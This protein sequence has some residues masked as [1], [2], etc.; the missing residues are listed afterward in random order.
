MK[1]TPKINEFSVFN[2]DEHMADLTNRVL[3]PGLS[4]RTMQFF[5]DRSQRAKTIAKAKADAAAATV[6][7]VASPSGKVTLTQV[8]ADD[9][10]DAKDKSY[11]NKHV[12][13][14]KEPKVLKRRRSK[15]MEEKAEL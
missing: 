15:K 14:A 13:A 8:E 11:K 5:L 7:A 4:K 3:D 12:Q 2:M 9:E 10:N 6:K 1:T